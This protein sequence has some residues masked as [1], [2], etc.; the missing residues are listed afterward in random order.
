MDHQP[1]K[2]LPFI[3]IVIPTFNRASFL[4]RCVGSLLEL[5]YP[6][7]KFEIIIINDG[8]TDA[9]QTVLFNN[10]GTQNG[11][12]KYFLNGKNEGAA[13][14]RNSG[15][16]RAQGEL[17]VSLD[18]DCL[19]ER[20]WLRDLVGTFSRFPYASA[21]GGSVVNPTQ[22]RLAQSSHIIEFSSWL[23]IGK[24]RPVKNIPTCNI[25]YRKADINGF[26]FPEEL[27]GSVYE[28]TLFNYNLFCSGRVII[29]DPKIKIYHY[30]WAGGFTKKDF[31]DSQARF[32]T[33]F[34]KGGYK[35]HG[36]SGVILMKFR[37]LNLLCLRLILVFFRCLRSKFYLRQF[38]R[39][40]R[41]I[42]GGEWA[43]N[44]IIYLGLSP[45]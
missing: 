2:E 38:I 24:A 28:D 23:P 20:S 43:R 22:T 10:F 17:I 42:L 3:S 21:V 8:S 35:A 11:K 32:A 45:G 37:A 6:Q 4:S 25:A 15:F 16:R 9:T 27:K 19:V 30:K 34:L 33:G 36:L 44:K 1:E 14:S 29:F 12:I 40:F 39:N 26:S 13:A 31:Y 5:D 41:L 7:G 18:D